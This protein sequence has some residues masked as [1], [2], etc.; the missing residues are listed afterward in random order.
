MV[1]SILKKLG[2]FIPILLTIV[3]T[4]SIMSNAKASPDIIYSDSED[5]SIYNTGSTFSWTIWAGDETTQP[6]IRG[7]VKFD[8]SS[9]PR[10]VSFATLNLYLYESYHDNS[11]DTT[12]PLTNPGLGD[13]LVIHIDDYG[14]LSGGDF[15]D[16]SI[17]NDPGVLISGLATPN[18]GYVSID[19]TAAMNDDINNGRSFSSFLIR[20]TTDTDGDVLRDR[21]QFRALGQ[22]GIE[23]DPYVEYELAPENPVGGTF[24]SADKIGLLSPWIA[25]ISIIGCI[26]IVS[27][28]VKKRRA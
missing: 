22:T 17:G 9:V 7:F 2:V 28:L 23:Q 5:G 25:T 26:A 8:I 10:R 12:S 27:I 1:D 15:N 3:L 6:T 16:P 14:T 19:V 11:M 18:I 24:Y 13:C 20:L 21:W 4:L